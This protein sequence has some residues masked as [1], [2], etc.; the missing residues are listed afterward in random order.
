MRQLRSSG[1]PE[2]LRVMSHGYPHRLPVAEARRTAESVPVP[3]G[4]ALVCTLRLGLP[5]V[6]FAGIGPE[7]RPHGHRILQQAAPHRGLNDSLQGL[8]LESFHGS[9]GGPPRRVA[10]GSVPGLLQSWPASSSAGADRWSSPG[11]RPAGG[12]APRGTRA[13]LARRLPRPAPRVALGAAAAPRPAP[14]DE[15]RRQSRA[16]PLPAAPLCLRAGEAPPA[17]HATAERGRVRRG[18][19][20]GAGGPREDAKEAKAVCLTGTAGGGCVRLACCGLGGQRKSCAGEENPIIL[21]A[22][23]L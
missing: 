16:L 18:D 21:H 7:L 17:G 15:G 12:S 1:V 20:V 9:L 23:A 5:S 3:A 22:S 4:G 14:A 10:L 2:L 8:S 13:A 19:A 6:L 11:P